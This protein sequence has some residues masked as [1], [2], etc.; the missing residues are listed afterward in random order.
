MLLLEEGTPTVPVSHVDKKQMNQFVM[1]RFLEDPE[2]NMDHQTQED[3][4]PEG[5][6]PQKTQ[7][8]DEDE[9]LFGDHIEISP[10]A[11]PY[12]NFIAKSP[13]Y[14]WLIAS[15]QRE[16]TVVRANPDIMENISNKILD[17]LPSDRKVSRKASSQEHKAT[18]E[19]DWDPLAFVKEQQ[20]T[21]SPDIALQRAITLI[22][23]ANDAQAV[24]TENYLSQTWPATGK[25]IMR[26]V[27]DV[28]LN[29]MDHHHACQYA[30][31]FGLL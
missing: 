7:E 3:F 8:E 21:E 6:F 4:N 13:A 23:S 20:Y 5:L 29:N 12:R 26:L 31:I 19:V 14:S 16:A 10:N 24:T 1:R 22:G 17:A 25:Q 9:D 15:L 27:M 11:T 2:I 18:F 28:V 30:Y